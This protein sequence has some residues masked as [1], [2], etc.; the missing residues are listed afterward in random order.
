MVLFDELQATKDEK[1]DLIRMALNNYSSPYKVSGY[2]AAT[3]N[4]LTNFISENIIYKKRK[5][6]TE[7]DLS[8]LLYKYTY[9]YF[10]QFVTP[11]STLDLIEMM[12]LYNKYLVFNIGENAMSNIFG[13]SERFEYRVQLVDS[14]ENI[15]HNSGKTFSFSIPYIANQYRSNYVNNFK[16]NPN[17]FNTAGKIMNINKTAD[18]FIIS[19]DFELRILNESSQPIVYNLTS[20]GA[21]AASVTLTK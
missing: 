2:D 14:P 12:I 13:L 15:N 8:S 18:G 5:D 20:G 7:N 9:R 3:L 1:L 10:T 19:T 11:V 17:Q 6:Y 4:N 16:L 21:K